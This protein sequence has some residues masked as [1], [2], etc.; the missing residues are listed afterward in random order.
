MMRF[1]SLLTIGCLLP[2][3]TFS[4]AVD[5]AAPAR[6]ISDDGYFRLA[7]ENDYFAARD[8]YYT[9][10]ISLQ[11]VHPGLYHFPLSK[12]LLR[13]KTSVMQYGL[14]VEH[15]AYTPQDY[16]RS[17]IQQGDRPFAAALF[18]K[19]FAIATD[20][21]KHQR[22]TTSLSTGIIGPGA[23][24]NEMQTGIHKWTNNPKPEGWH[25]QVANDVVLNYQLN[26]EKQ[27]FSLRNYLCVSADAMARVG[28]L[29]DKANI[30]LTVMGGYFALP[31]SANAKRKF[32]LY[33]YDHPELNFVAYDATMQ[34][35]V[36]DH[37]SPYVLSGSDV[38]HIVFR[39]NW[40]VVM[41]IGNL[42]LEYFQTFLTKEF[43]NG[44][45]H[46]YG[47]IQVGVGF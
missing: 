40:G 8:Y 37:D 39:N 41:Q 2:V 35:G 10:G 9:Q 18:L 12:L 27:L 44:I 26:Y 3:F 15:N 13:P 32:R 34:G 25:N 22:I 24:G 29:S 23:G 46:R 4:Q 21:V 30:G 7:Y 28:T 31:F 47:G 36:F 42:Y 33:A 1:F 19:T 11:F 38:T 17:E 14:A 45:D 6:S 43:N 16:T 5:N 20:T